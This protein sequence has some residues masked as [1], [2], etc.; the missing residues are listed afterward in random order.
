MVIMAIISVISLFS[1]VGFVA[2][3]KSSKLKNEARRL[4]TDLRLAQQ[5]AITEQNFYELRLYPLSS[6]YQVV[7]AA[8]EEIVKEVFFDAEVY[9]GDIATLTDN[10]VIF[11]PTGA[12]TETGAVYLVNSKNQTS[13]V[14][15]KPSGYVNIVD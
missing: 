11:N 14:E 7:N 8:T 15:I 10:I 5:Y 13:T 4:A 9:I 1:T 12:V 6:S 2:Y 3:Q